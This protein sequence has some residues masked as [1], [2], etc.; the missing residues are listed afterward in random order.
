MSQVESATG[1]HQCMQMHVEQKLSWPQEGWQGF[2][3]Y[4]VMVGEET[5]Q[6]WEIGRSTWFMT[7]VGQLNKVKLP[8]T[9][10]VKND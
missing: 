6:G 2:C 5:K 10:K 9:S 4:V 3:P 8:T 1:K 7:S